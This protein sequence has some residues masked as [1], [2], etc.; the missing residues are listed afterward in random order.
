MHKMVYP[1]RSW[2]VCDHLRVIGAVRQVRSRLLVWA[3]Q[4]A[5]REDGSHRCIVDQQ[6]NIDVI[7][8]GAVENG[9]STIAGAES[10]N[11]KFMTG[12][13]GF[14]RISSY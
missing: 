13:F 3:G 2:D 7:S 11:N 5:G 14:F 8:T 10:M 9:G 12:P 6:D 4:G 1:W